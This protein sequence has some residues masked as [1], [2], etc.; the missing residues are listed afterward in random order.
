MAAEARWLYLV[1]GASAI[2]AGC[3]DRRDQVAP[4]PDACTECH[5]SEMRAAPP[6]DLDGNSSPDAPGVGAHLVHLLR[7]P[8]HAPVACTECHLVPET[9]WSEG[10][11]DSELPADLS[12]GDLAR[13]GDRDPSYDPAAATCSDTYCHRAAPT[14]WT[15]PRSSE[16]A[17]GSCHGVPPEPPHPAEADCSRC[18]GAVID[19]ARRLVAPDA[20]VDGIV[21]V[22]TT[23]DTCHGGP[24][25]GASFPDAAGAH[26][27]HLTGGVR[28]RPLPCTECHV[29]P[30]RVGDPGHLDTSV[31]AEVVLGAIATRAGTDARWDRA[32]RTCSGT[33]CH[34]PSDPAAS[35]SPVW[36]ADADPPACGSCHGLPPPGVGGNNPRCWECHS[37]LTQALEFRDRTRHVNGVINR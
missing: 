28:S 29:E 18:H 6:R 33:W 15:R 11:L 3:L 22:A 35:V 36:T 5:G 12:F 21:D 23:C 4:E 14:T 13:F 31:G 9:I 16:A 26:Q 34:G 20:H 37:N 27:A 8:T 7:S 32:S 2:V 10:H 17:C 1:I 30:L 19:E 25:S 24:T